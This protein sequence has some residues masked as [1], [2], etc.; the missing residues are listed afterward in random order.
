MTSSVPVC[1][2]LIIWCAGFVEAQRPSPVASR[3]AAFHMVKP[4]RGAPR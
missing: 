3:G 2:S 4:S 1:F